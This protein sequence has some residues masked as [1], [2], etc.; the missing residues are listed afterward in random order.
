MEAKK[1]VRLRYLDMLKQAKNMQEILQ[2]EKEVN[3]IQEQIEAGEGRVNYLSHA[4]AYSTIQLTFFQVLN[5]GAVVNDNPGF[6]KRIL[7]AFSDGL[8]WIGELMIIFVTLWPM[9]L[10]IA[11][12]IFVVRKVITA[13][14]VSKGV[15][16][17]K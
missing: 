10:A 6:G 2:V 3:D 7:L 15:N 12:G 9:W 8:H 17:V 4:A 14:R 11:I 16:T 5:A 1:K 13:A